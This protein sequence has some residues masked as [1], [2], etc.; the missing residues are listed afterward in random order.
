MCTQDDRNDNNVNN[1]LGVFPFQTLITISLRFSGELVQEN[2]LSSPLATLSELIHQDTDVEP[3]V[4][5][6]T[7]NNTEVAISV[8]TIRAVLALGGANDDPISYPGTLIMGC[9]QRMGYRGKPNDSQAR[10]GGLAGTDGLKSDLQAAMVALTLN[11]QFNFALYIYHDLVMQINPP[12]VQGFLMYPR[13]LQ[14]ILN[15]LIPDL[16]QHP[17]RLT[18]TPM[19][20]RIFTDCTKVK[21]HNITL[22]PVLTPLFGHIINPNYVEPPNDNWFHHEELVQGQDQNQVQQQQQQEAQAH[23]QAHSQAHEQVPLQQEQVQI[24]VNIPVN[25]PV[26]GEDVANEDEQDFGLNMDDFNDAA[27]NSPM[28]DAEGNVVDTSY[29]DTILPDSDATDSDSSRDFSSDHYERLATFPLAN[30]GKRIKSKARKP[31]RKSVQDP[32][33]GSVFGKRTLIDESSDSDR[34]VTPVPKAQKLMSASIAAAHS[35][36]GVEDATFVESLLIT[37]PSSKCPSPVI[38]PIPK[39]TQSSAAGPSQPSDSERIT[40]LESQVLALQNQGESSTSGNIEGTKKDSEVNEE[41]LLLEFFQTD[42]DAE[43]EE[44]E[45]IKCLDDIDELFN[46]VEDVM[47]DNEVEEGEIVEIEIEKS[48]VEVTYKGCDGLNVPY[49][50]IQDEVIPVFSNEGVT[51]S[52]DFVEDTTEKPVMYRNTCMTREQRREVVN[53]WK[54]VLPKSPIQSAQ[55]ERYVNKERCIERIISWFYDDESKLCALKRS[56]GVQYLKPRIKY[57]NTLPRCEMSGLATKPLIKRS[58]FGLAD[59]IDKLICKEGGSGKYEKL[60]PQKGKRVKIVDPSTSI[61]TW[62]YKFKPLR[63]V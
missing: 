46:D 44:P 20:K 29:S 61:V 51:Y 19:Y 14:M 27:M 40:Y 32:P 48:K 5:R 50:M 16:S 56:D 57:F 4:L 60:K 17:I 41:I 33:S 34:E 23:A 38:S 10:K 12:E 21:Q 24:P 28:H 62:K 25:E 36:Q 2:L 39:A 53:S 26:Q 54:K 47:T 37:P 55:K 18:L 9:F 45:K 1:L 35:S 8:D 15:H 63:A 22:I 42:S 3:H 6:D 43:E 13:F 49:N 11:K 7:I 59:V 31:R 58:K 30:A 52:M